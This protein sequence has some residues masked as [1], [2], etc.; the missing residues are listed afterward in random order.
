[1]AFVQLLIIYTTF[2][3]H[4]QKSVSQSPEK[5]PMGNTELK[6]SGYSLL[7]RCGE[8]PV[9]QS[10]TLSVD[11]SCALVPFH[12]SKTAIIGDVDVFPLNFIPLNDHWFCSWIYFKAISACEIVLWFP[13][14]SF[15]V[16]GRLTDCLSVGWWLIHWVT[17]MKRFQYLHSI[18]L[19]DLLS[20]FFIAKVR[21]FGPHS[22]LCIF[23]YRPSLT[24]TFWPTCF[25]NKSWNC[26]DLYCF[27][28]KFQYLHSM[29]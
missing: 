3:S 1:M 9:E 13:S 26:D 27:V 5:S 29:T 4:D 2:Q 7:N 25:C 6:I 19:T 28:N 10:M 14:A 18:T 21:K 20:C 17:R 8:V 23:Q 11:I 12:V 15:C 24:V 22:F 16:A